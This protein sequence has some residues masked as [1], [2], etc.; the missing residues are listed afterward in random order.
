MIHANWVPCAAEVIAAG[1]PLDLDR[2]AVSRATR[3]LFETVEIVLLRTG[4]ERFE[5]EVWC[6]F[7]PWLKTALE[8][9]AG[10]L[11]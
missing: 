8:T 6:S 11:R 3:T 9:A 5:I 4:D 1:C 7:A 10:Q 2:F